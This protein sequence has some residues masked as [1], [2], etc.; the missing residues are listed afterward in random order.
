MSEESI[1]NP[2]K[3]PAIDLV[4]AA[5]AKFQGEVTNPA[6]SRQVNVS[7]Q[8]GSYSFKYAELSGILDYCRP[9]LAK[10]GLAVSDLIDMN[11]NYLT[12]VARLMHSSGQ[13]LQSQMTIPKPEKIQQVGSAITYLRRYSISALIGI[14]DMDDDD[15]NTAHGNTINDSK[16]VST[17]RPSQSKFS[18][19]PD[20]A[21]ASQPVENQIPADGDGWVGA[22]SHQEFKSRLATCFATATQMKVSGSPEAHKQLSNLGDEYGF[23]FR[24]GSANPVYTE[25]SLVVLNEALKIAEG[26]TGANAN[27]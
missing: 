9:V 3:E 5:L 16:K 11:V 20:G 6:K 2:F 19:P 23:S 18:G 27:A 15:G 4:S 8:G 21:K 25:V 7:G 12:V 22:S 10:N 13:F 14:A 24:A 26:L 17:P 1:P